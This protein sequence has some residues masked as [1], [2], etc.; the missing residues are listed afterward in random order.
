[1]VDTEPNGGIVDT[2]EGVTLRKRFEEGGNRYPA[3][4]YEF[5]SDRDEAVS[6]RVIDPV[7]DGL[8]P[9]DVGFRTSAESVSWERK[10]PKLVLDV[11]LAP[12]GECTTACATRASDAESI[13]DLLDRPQVFEVE[14]ASVAAVVA[15][16]TPIITDP[17]DEG[18]A[19]VDG[20]E[21]AAD[22]GSMP[23][24]DGGVVEQFVA[25]LRDG[26]VPEETVAFLER[27]IG[28]PRSTPKSVDVRLRQLQADLADVRAYTN[29]LESFL[30]KN[31]TAQD[32]GERFESRVDEVDEA[33]E[34]I[35]ATVVDHEAELSDLR[36]AVES[37][38]GD[39]RSMT[40]ELERLDESVSALD[41][42]LERIEE[43]LP[44]EGMDER[45]AEIET[46]LDR[47]AEFTD[48]LR[49]VFVD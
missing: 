48:E 13:R 12:F 16:K 32:L 14:P 26:T 47:V 41:A 8:P 4:A 24:V 10:G 25:E 36:T 42:T 18:D 20:S 17:V 7:P 27:E 5:N 34:S 28:S 35:D 2:T 6:V 23:E 44:D 39:V 1:M 31:G 49:A 46:E 33:V 15:E 40:S 29:A 37:L 3:V 11:E 22:R 9:A 43:R 45:V 19:P 21:S 38:E 30:D